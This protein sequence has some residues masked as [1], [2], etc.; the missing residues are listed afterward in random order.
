MSEPP[1]GNRAG[2]GV[3]L[4]DVARR[5]GVS[6]MTAS[7]ALSN[8][9]LVAE[10]TRKQVL[11]AVQDTGYVPNLYAAGLRS[12]RTRTVACMVPTIA[13]GSAF[14]Q[15][16]QS[17]NEA[18]VE[19]GYQVMLYERGYDRSRDDAVLDA[20]L[21][22]RPDGIALTGA[23]RSVSARERLKAAGIPV[24]ETWDMTDSPVDMVVGFSH[25]DVGRTIARYLHARGRRRVA[26]ID[27]RESRTNARFTGFAQ[28][29]L[30]LG[31]AGSDL[32]AGT[33]PVMEPPSKLS[34]GREALARALEVDAQTDALYAATDM[35]AMGA[36][37]EAQSRG[38]RVPDDVAIVGFGDFDFSA[39]T[40]PPLT[41][42]RV[43]NG[44]IGRRAA[45]M[46]IAKIEGRE[47][48]AKT[49]DVG[50]SLIERL[51]S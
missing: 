20:V 11:A 36:L 17:M 44:G 16:L 10:G 48:S 49:I 5:A 42:V 8:P 18:F 46:L 9:E 7:R 37:M 40:V 2:V 15:A 47:E 45:Q 38:L 33:T 39:D 32:Q 43:D 24:V 12:K 26:S 25:Y 13:S 14:L 30:R 6:K 27:G 4:A 35:V 28:E 29:A 21:A 3:T 1:T 51:S 50:F 23:T 31:I 22:R 19:A 34:F 41:T